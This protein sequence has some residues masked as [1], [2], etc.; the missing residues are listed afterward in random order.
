MGHT[1]SR[2]ENSSRPA[3]LE[4]AAADRRMMAEGRLRVLARRHQ[5]LVK[6]LVI[7]G[8]ASAIDVTLF[9]LLFNVVGTTALAAH[10]VS[11]PAA[12]L[13]S[14]FMNARH[15]FRTHDLMALRLLSFAIVC[16]IGYLAGYGVI[17]AA[18]ALGLGENIGKILSLPIVFVIQYV[19]NSRI[20]FRRRAG[21]AGAAS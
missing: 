3:A 10:S 11:V 9:L 6:Y 2:L 21:A 1:M 15:N 18:A 19:L 17:E 13:F 5:H 7:G 12:V 16:V 20:T 8:A 4:A 14:F